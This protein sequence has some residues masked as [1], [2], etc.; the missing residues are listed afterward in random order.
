MSK[1]ILNPVPGLAARHQQSGKTYVDR[2]LQALLLVNLAALV[3]YICLSYK[4]GFHSDSAAS[5]LLAHEI[6]ETGSYFPVDWNYVNGDLWVLS[7]HTWLLPFLP[8][9]SNG[10]ALHALGGLISAALVMAG[11]WCL[12]RTLGLS[13]R[14]R[15]VTLAL[16][17]SGFSA[18]MSENL[19]GQQA[20]GTIYFL[21]CFLL[22][23][24]HA[25][26]YS[27]RQPAAVWALASFVLLVLAA[28]SNPMRAAIYNVLPV[29]A[30]AVWCHLAPR[31]QGPKPGAAK[32]GA[33]LCIVVG[34]C[35]VGALLHAYFLARGH[36]ALS[37]VS[38]N[39]LP[40]K[41]MGRNA[42]AALQGSFSLLSGLP[43][44]GQPVA[45]VRGMFDA[46]RLCAGAALLFVSGWA[47]LRILGSVHPGRLFIGVAT[48]AAIGSNLFIFLTTT[49][50]FVETP[51]SSIR[52]L[53][54][55]LLG[56]M[57]LLVAVVV[58]D[59]LAPAAKRY[60]GAIAI[61]VIALTAPM[62]YELT[63]LTDHA[64]LRDMNNA[65]QNVRLANF[66]LDNKLE[67]GYATFWNA[68][69]TTVLAKNVVKVRNIEL[70]NGLPRPMRHLSSDRW[71]Q[72]GSWSGQSFLMLTKE[73]LDAVKWPE[74][75]RLTG[76]PL[77]TLDF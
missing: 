34:A 6:G 49:L 69:R 10:Y 65:N 45:N 70:A 59:R 14:A 61:A 60:V 68:G 25:F 8:F 1:E 57:V 12:C 52:Y 43:A 2:V 17:A 73:E 22:C 21:G 4:F 47:L 15:L 9:M 53:V 5:N 77:R 56:M 54:P 16:I 20:Y 31:L 74:L 55:A 18:N 19:F 11:T 23:T 32:L 48:L 40:F 44:P 46:V 38:I 41:D 36:S 75:R 13:S 28:W 33:L 39:W 51:E 64:S 30:A 24:S 37:S 50:P 67:Y 76:E 42:G 66:L 29:V 7:V 71:Y 35:Y 72:P 3:L 63:G 27:K 62:A 58:D 26:L